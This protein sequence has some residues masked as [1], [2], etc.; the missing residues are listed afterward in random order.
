MK[1]YLDGKE[2]SREEYVKAFNSQKY[3]RNFIGEETHLILNLDKRNKYLRIRRKHALDNGFDKWE[4][5]MLAG[6]EVNDPLVYQW[7]NNLLDINTTE[8][9]LQNIPER[10]AYYLGGN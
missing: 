9:A 10:V 8:E 7:Y 4:K 2:L 6:R 3:D 1:Y 5:A